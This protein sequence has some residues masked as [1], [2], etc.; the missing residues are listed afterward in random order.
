M[1][2][3]EKQ[4]KNDPELMEEKSVCGWEEKKKRRK[5]L[6]LARDFYFFV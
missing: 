1:E 3:M 5:L 4:K 6:F 2:W